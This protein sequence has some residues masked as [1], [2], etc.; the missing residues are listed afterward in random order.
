MVVHYFDLNEFAVRDSHLARNYLY[1]LVIPEYQM[2]VEYQSK[3][4][5]A[6]PN[7]TDQEWH[8]WRQPHNQATADEITEYEREKC[9]TIFNK[10][11]Y[12]MWYVWEQTAQEDVTTILCYLK[13]RTMKF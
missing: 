5:H 4:Y 3:R 12:Y 13:T 9:R 11:C 8:Q 1:D 6:W 2:A 7:M 10:Y